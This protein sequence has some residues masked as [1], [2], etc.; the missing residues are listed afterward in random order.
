[1][2]RGRHE[3]PTFVATA[4]LLEPVV[5]AIAAAFVFGERPAPF[6]AAGAL[7]ILAAIALAIRAE[8]P[9]RAVIA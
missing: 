1:V 7:L 6:T 9:A 4:T 3:R 2:R 5:A 8:A